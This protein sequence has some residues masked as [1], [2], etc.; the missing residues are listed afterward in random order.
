MGYAKYKEDIERTHSLNIF[1]TWLDFQGLPPIQHHRCPFCSFET[2]AK[3]L[4]ETH[5]LQAHRDAAIF[6]EHDDRIVPD[7]F[8]TGRLR[9]V[10][11]K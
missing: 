6:L 11:D 4:L 1:G 3:D 9:K 7:G 10:V 8:D 2:T 5:L